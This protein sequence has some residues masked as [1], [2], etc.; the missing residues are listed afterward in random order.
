VAAGLAPL[1]LGS[2]TGGSIRQPAAFC[3]VVGVK[4][5]Y[6]AV[7]R[8]GLVAFASSLD[9]IG[10]FGR[11]VAD[12]ALLLRAIAGHDPRDATSDPR[13]LDFDGG[14]GVAGLR[15]G[16]PAEFFGEGLDAEIRAALE[17]ARRVF[18]DLGAE[19]REVSLPLSRHGIAVYYLV[20]PCEASS[21]LARYDGV[22]Y[23]IRGDDAG[24][25]GAM[26]RSTRGEGFG[27]EVKRRILLGTFALSSGYYEAYYG[28]AQKVRAAMRAEMDRVFAEIDLLLTPVTPTPPF[29]L[30][31]KA[32]D[33]LAMYLNDVLTVTANLCGIPALAMPCG[34][35][36]AYLPVGLQLMGPRFGEGTILRAARAYET[37]ARLGPLWPPEVEA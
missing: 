32:S 21:N 35:T 15:L 6:G 7:S 18:E 29:R 16:L 33:P 34:R 13:P 2:D 5:T 14:G 20:A 36:K 1:A 24:D 30:G 31:E 26:F 37:A 10:P 25:V 8:H 3:G 27:P 19:T 28:R 9:Q 17:K 11:S 4:P 23:G 12:A 22:R